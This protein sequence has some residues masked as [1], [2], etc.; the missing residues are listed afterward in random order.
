LNHL[1][2]FESSSYQSLDFTL[3]KIFSKKVRLILPFM[4]S[5]K[6]LDKIMN[7]NKRIEHQLHNSLSKYQTIV[8]I[9]SILINWYKI[10]VSIVKQFLNLTQKLF[11]INRQYLN[12]NSFTINKDHIMIPFQLSKPVARAS[13]LWLPKTCW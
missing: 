8:S 12:Q 6:I 11:I 10:I 9:V 2:D 13:T 7:V 1:V 5:T 4:H 3:N